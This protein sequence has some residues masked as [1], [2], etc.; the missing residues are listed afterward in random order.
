MFAWTGTHLGAAAGP[1]SVNGQTQDGPPTWGA[2]SITGVGIPNSG[3]DSGNIILTKSDTKTSNTFSTFY[4]YPQITSYTAAQGDGDVQSGTITITGNHFGSGGTGANISVNSVAPSSIGVWSATSITTVDIPNT[5][6]DS[7]TITVTS[8]GTSKA[9]NASSA[10]YIYPQVTSL[11]IC[12]KSGFPADTAREYS[13]SDTACPN[14]LKDGSL[15]VNGNHFGSPAGANPL[16]V[17]GSDV[18]GYIS[19]SATLVS[20]AQVPAAINDASYTGA[21]M[22]ARNDTKQ[23]T[24]AGFRILPR[25]ASLTPNSGVIGTDVTVAGDHL[26]QTG[27]CPLASSWNATQNDGHD[28]KWDSTNATVLATP[29]EPTHTSLYADAPNISENTYTVT[30]VSGGGTSYTSNGLTFTINTSKPN[31]PA[32]IYQFKTNTDTAEPPTANVAVGA[33]INQANAWFRMDMSGP[34][35]GENYYAQ[36][37]AKPIGTAFECI[38]TSPSPCT[39]TSGVFAEGSGVTYNGT[40]VQ[41]F[42]Q[43]TGFTNGTSYH[44]Q[45]RVRN[46]AGAS[47]WMSFGGNAE[48][49]ADFY[50]DT[51][52]PTIAACSFH[53]SV[54]ASGATIAWSPSDNV[55]TTFTKQ[56]QYATTTDFVSAV[57]T[58]GTTCGTPTSGLGGNP[59]TVTLTGLAPNTTYYY[60]VRSKDGAENEKVVG[61]GLS[62]ETGCTF[63]TSK[64]NMKTVEYFIT[65]E[66]G[67]VSSEVSRA[68]TVY[69]ADL[70]YTVQ[71]AFVEISGNAA[72]VAGPLSL[73]L[74][75]VGGSSPQSYTTYSINTSTSAPTP[76]SIIH[77]VPASS[78]YISPNDTSQNQLWISPDI[79]VNIAS[80]K[81][82]LT[83]YY[84][85]Q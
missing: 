69:I 76:F 11:T 25:I 22:L 14:G 73:Q 78:L 21:I 4:I 54:T 32:N 49:A 27:T 31:N 42:A 36:V 45:A 41:G 5:G 84:T 17:L 65:G 62:G 77:Q 83:Y 52:A 48:S 85:P 40:A 26:C 47:N 72:A 82:V 44:W 71:N 29:A 33:G 80:A 64:A 50:S 16:T 12:D 43:A 75:V 24:Y 70:G 81:I 63:L 1:I 30:V 15:H 46:S 61:Y 58:P 74:K 60:R 23:S 10:F 55:S 79:G 2:A 59:Q 6:T 37:E 68:F 20:T 3:T 39:V 51:T 66:T 38:N 28:V 57:C 18:S 35:T 67:T 34:M 53:S 8:P 13:A 56:A 19:W 9:S 7:G